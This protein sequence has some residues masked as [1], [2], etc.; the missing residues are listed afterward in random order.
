MAV[1]PQESDAGAADR[2][3][4]HHRLL[5]AGDEGN[6]Q[7]SRE[8]LV[9]H[10]IGE[11]GVGQRA[12]DCAAG[13]ESVLAVGQV[14]RVGGSDDHDCGEGERPESGVDRLF[15]ERHHQLAHQHAELRNP[16]QVPDRKSRDQELSEQFEFAGNAV[17]PL[18][19]HLHEIVVEADQRESERAQDQHNR[20]RIVDLVPENA[21]DEGCADQQHA[22]HAGSPVLFPVDEFGGDEALQPGGGLCVQRLELPGGPASEQD[23][24]QKG[25]QSRAAGPER[26]I[27][28]EAQ[29]PEMIA[30]LGEKVK[31]RSNKL[32]I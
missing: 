15:E 14:H 10:Q 31:H 13:R 24:Q 1:V 16:A 20:N 32:S 23:D 19:D 8:N 4:E 2:G 12:E 6:V 22:A 7:V 3:R 28:E 21:A 30:E 27:V 29:R 18:V 11:G 26:H 17:A 5:G 25:G 9:S